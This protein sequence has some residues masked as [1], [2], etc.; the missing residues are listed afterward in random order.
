MVVPELSAPVQC[1]HCEDAPCRN[2]CQ[3][4]AISRVDG[5]T[6]V[7]TL[8]CVGCRLC[9]MACPFGAI[10][11][12][13]QP[14]GTRPVYPGAFSGPEGWAGRRYHRANNCDLCV[15]RPEGPA[16][17]ET[18]PQKALELV[19]PAAERNRRN[20]EAALDLLEVGGGIGGWKP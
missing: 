20:A 6:V 19:H 8:K 17:V 18:C 10:E 5:R 15:H 11:F 13:P 14:E 4:S 2:V 7:D 12:V 1:H 9:L 3:M 16:C